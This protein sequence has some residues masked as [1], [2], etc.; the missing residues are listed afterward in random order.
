MIASLAMQFDWDWTRAERE[1]RA[2][3]AAGPSASAE[4]IYGLLLTYR[5]RF[6]EADDHLR[7]AQ[8]LDPLGTVQLNNLSLALVLE[9]RFAQAREESEKILARYPNML[10]TRVGVDLIYVF[11]GQPSLALQGLRKLEHRFPPALV[12]EAMAEARAGHRQNALTLVRPFEANYQDGRVPM[13]W[14]ALVY[15]LLGDEANTVKWLERSA[16]RREWPVLNIAVHPVFASMENTPRF[17]ALKK[18]MR[19]E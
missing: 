4:S 14:F 16:D 13:Y 2:A 19:L 9:K 6:A 7:R 10:P 5:G 1:L 12:G 3:A 8:D 11:E 17:R 15:G 18:R